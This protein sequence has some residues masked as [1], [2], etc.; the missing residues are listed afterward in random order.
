MK[1]HVQD[2]ETVIKVKIAWNIFT[3]IKS[4]VN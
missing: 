3:N 4:K 2:M 1:V